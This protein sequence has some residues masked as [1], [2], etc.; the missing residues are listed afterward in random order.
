MGEKLQEVSGLVWATVFSP[1][2]GW[3]WTHNSC[4]QGCCAFADCCAM[5]HVNN[6][7]PSMNTSQH[8]SSWVRVGHVKKKNIKTRLLEEKRASSQLQKP[9][10]VSIHEWFL[11][12]KKTGVRNCDWSVWKNLNGSRLA[13]RLRVHSDRD[14]RYET[15]RRV[16]C[17]W[18]PISYSPTGSPLGP[19]NIIWSSYSCE[20]SWFIK[21]DLPG[22]RSLRDWKPDFVY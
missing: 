2:I 9:P 5:V 22:F 13:C 10:H 6:Y 18:P 4:Q 8:C 3:G 16:L 17:L 1:W 7:N 11:G 12:G 14:W 20:I 21:N 15:V 19:S